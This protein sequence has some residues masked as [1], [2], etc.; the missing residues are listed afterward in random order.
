MKVIWTCVKYIAKYIAFLNREKLHTMEITF[1]EA[2][3]DTSHSTKNDH[4]K[5]NIKLTASSTA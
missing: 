4:M 2:E 1:I 5:F 3:D